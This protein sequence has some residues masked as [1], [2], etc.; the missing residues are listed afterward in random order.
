MSSTQV[1]TSSLT[2]VVCPRCHGEAG[3]ISI[4]PDLFGL[5]R[6]ERRVFSCARCGWRA[7]L[8]WTEHES[9]ASA[10]SRDP[11]VATLCTTCPRTHRLIRTGIEADEYALHVAAYSI[12]AVHCGECERSHRVKIKHMFLLPPPWAPPSRSAAET[13][14]RIAR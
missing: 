6:S 2:G 12:I 4:G 5:N 9:P 3:L 1:Q 10:C 11:P 14:A 7:S 13:N 8:R